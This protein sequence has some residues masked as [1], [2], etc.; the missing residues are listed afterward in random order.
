[1]ATSVDAKCVG[2]LQ[3]CTLSNVLMRISMDSRSTSD[4]K[5]VSVPRTETRGPF[6]SASG[7]GS[8]G[9][10]DW[11]VVRGAQLPADDG[12]GG[13]RAPHANVQHHPRLR[14]RSPVARFHVQKFTFSSPLLAAA[15]GK[16]KDWLEEKC[17]GWTC[18][19]LA[20]YCNR[21]SCCFTGPK[22][23]GYL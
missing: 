9:G 15:S 21:P 7:T 17:R 4:V 2:P 11:D 22:G 23:G 20:A 10:W 16:A 5:Y 14:E 18:H 19:S 13:R 8:S 1:M 12:R 3:V 6:I